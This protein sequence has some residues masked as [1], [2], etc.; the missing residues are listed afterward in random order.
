LELVQ[1][2]S[3]NYSATIK[4]Y[5]SLLKP[6][7]MLLVVFTGAVGLFAAPVSLGIFT[8]ALVIAA[9]AL[10]SGAGAAIN[11]WYDADIDAIMS[12][13]QRRA[14]PSG[15]IPR[16]DIL[17]TG[18]TLALLSVALLGLS[19]NWAAGSLLAF[20]IWFYGCFYT[21]ILKRRTAQNIVIGGAAGAFPP[22][23]G[24]LAAE[25]I[26]TLEPIIYFLIIFF[27][28]PPHFWALALYRH[29]DYKKANIPML[30]VTSGEK[31]T[32]NNILGYSVVL[33]ITGLLPTILG[34]LSWVYGSAAL[35]L[36]AVFL[37]KAYQLWHKADNKKAMNLF[38]Y[39]IIYLFVLFSFV[40]VDKIVLGYFL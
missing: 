37:L 16:D 32:L 3:S 25:P 38:G 19:T 39:S 18:L 8:S 11:M 21:M 10:G 24:W 4:D 22:M 28:T 1:P 14:A 6:G 13:T 12:R 35:A 31:V 20:A 26:L 5:W 15:K 34:L 23:I 2:Q 36:N 40:I 7:V 17:I 9:I 33:F 29:D 30:P 27:W